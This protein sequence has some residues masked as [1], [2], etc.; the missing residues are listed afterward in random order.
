MISDPL[1]GTTVGSYQIA[2]KIGTGGMGAVYLGIHP[3]IHK[4]V[5]IKVLHP[6]FADKPDVVQR[7]FQEAR[8]VSVLQHPHIVELIDFG[9]LQTT[10]YL[11]YCVME[12]LEGETLR[13]RLKR[14]SVSES[15]AIRIARQIADAVAA[16]HRQ[17]IIHRDLKPDNIFLIGPAGDHV[18]ILDFGI[19]KLTGQQASLQTQA[20]TLLGTPAYMSPE[21]CM[22]RAVDGRT[23]IYALGAL[24]FEMGTGRVPF[25]GDGYADL[26]IK[27]INSPL[28]A[29]RTINPNLSPPL[30]RVIQRALEKDP[31]A[32][33][34]SMEEFAAALDEL[35]TPGLT[36]L[37]PDQTRRSTAVGSSWSSP[38][39][40]TQLR[41]VAPAAANSRAWIAVAA[42]VV[43]GGIVCYVALRKPPQPAADAPSRPLPV[44][45]M[46]LHFASNPAGA[47]VVREDG[48]ELG[49]TPL[50]T[51]LSAN[52]SLLRITIEREGYKPEVRAIILGGRDT[53]LDFNL[54]PLASDPPE[55]P[56]R[57][58]PAN[59]MKKPPAPAGEPQVNPNDE[60]MVPRL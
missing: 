32:R 30:E 33:F 18:K 28:P 47:R 42:A 37:D 36:P 7:F 21:Q 31:A 20:G 5:A 14:G 3:L 1:V 49:R 34:Q 59:E 52:G 45:T 57:R 56:K 40:P 27:Q 50:D 2:S 15:E 11:H 8:A 51:E 19:A 26:L 44:K 55:R 17:Q 48:A 54:V 22:A 53:S 23:D 9:Q 46:R 24:L 41:S 39:A 16:A 38:T 58:H 43:L 13:D 10:P 25:I 12:L 6:E 35:R 4:K 60:I 29:P